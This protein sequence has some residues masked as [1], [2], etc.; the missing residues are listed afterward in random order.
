MLQQSSRRRRPNCRPPTAHRV[1][2]A[3]LRSYVPHA[4]DARA[5][6]KLKLRTRMRAPADSYLRLAQTDGRTDGQTD[7]RVGQSC[8][9]NC[10]SVDGGGGG[11]E[12]ARALSS[13]ASQCQ[14]SDCHGNNRNTDT[15]LCLL[16]PLATETELLRLVGESDTIRR[17]WKPTQTQRGRPRRRL[18]S[19]EADQYADA[20][21]RMD[22]SETQ[23]VLR[24]HCHRDAGQSHR[25]G[26]CAELP[27]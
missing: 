24:D 26:V 23:Q 1:A 13:P 27:D 7:R 20:G 9:R 10:A 16:R 14:L 19:G 25:K 18:V 21:P 6:N 8:A 4:T 17:K 11:P 22:P 12:M 5:N 15:N 2:R 3:R